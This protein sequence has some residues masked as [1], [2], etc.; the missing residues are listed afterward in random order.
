MAEAEANIEHTDGASRD[1]NLRMPPVETNKLCTA[2][3]RVISVGG[4]RKH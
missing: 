4:T 3:E 1:D 2:T